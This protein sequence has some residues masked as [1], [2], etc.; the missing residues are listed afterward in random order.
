[1]RSN[2]HAG[3]KTLIFLNKNAHNCLFTSSATPLGAI[4]LYSQQPDLR[5]KFRKLD[6]HCR[7]WQS[8][9]SGE[10]VIDDPPPPATQLQALIQKVQQYN[11]AQGVANSLDSKL[12]NA[13]AALE[14]L[15]S[16]NV[17]TDCNKLD[18]FINAVET[19]NELT[20]AQATDLIKAASRIKRTLSCDG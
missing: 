12:Q 4:S 14:S 5:W 3:S 1:M 9:S 13:L 11:F 8:Q 6:D 15:N 17:G 20:Q 16:G 19:K 7:R 10:H 2:D 18:S